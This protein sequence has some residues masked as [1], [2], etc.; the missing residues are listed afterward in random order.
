MGE[1]PLTVEDS[2]HELSLF[3][4]TYNAI[5]NSGCR[6]IGEIIARPRS[7]WLKQK[8]AGI[9]TVADLE[10]ELSK[11][12]FALAE[13]PARVS[14]KGRKI[15]MSNVLLCDVCEQRIP[16]EEIVGGVQ[17]VANTTG[18]P[19]SLIVEVCRT[20]MPKVLALFHLSEERT[21]EVMAEVYERPMAD[22]D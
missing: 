15:Q 6:T 18:R 19:R 16:Y 14:R 9:V 8:N 17:V 22:I 10:L 1:L 5:K 11:H 20:C 3:V 7:M 2:Y 12:G 21:Q 4:R 13:E